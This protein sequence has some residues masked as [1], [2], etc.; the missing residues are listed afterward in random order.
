MQNPTL[1]P[2]FAETIIVLSTKGM[3][4]STY[5][6]LAAP[7]G[8]PALV[9]AHANGFNAGCYR[10][11]LERLSSHFQV[12][13]YDARGHGGSL[14]PDDDIEN[15]Y[16]MIRFAE[17]L[18]AVVKMVRELIGNAMLLHFASHSVGGLAAILLE[19]EL[20]CT[21][22]NSLTLFEPP[23]YPPNGHPERAAAL[24]HAPNFI[25]WAGRRRD[26]FSSREALLAEVRKINTYQRFAPEMMEAYLNSVVE[27]AP[28]GGLR[29]R[30][31]GKI[32]SAIYGNCPNSGIFEL[33][34]KVTTRARI[35]STDQ[36]VLVNLH[37]WAP[38][39]MV[40]IAE[41]MVNGEARTMPGCLHLMVQENPG[42][43]AVAILDHTLDLGPSLES[44]KK[45]ENKT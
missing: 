21:P 44:F 7:E 36:S 17:D 23:I 20:E 18:S 12:F 33:M 27:P 25:R 45:S 31:P 42:A 29:L 32:E 8:A 28:T 39:T 5:R 41:N 38:N 13:A 6:V 43:C 40:S 11:F 34:D 1:S 19:A 2:D 26:H 3:K 22:F 15:D 37:S 4:V 9:F 24:A 16:A 14:S 30:C 35:Y 10:P